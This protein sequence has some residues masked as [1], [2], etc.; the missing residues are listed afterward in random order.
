MNTSICAAVPKGD[1]V[2]LFSCLFVC[3]A[4]GPSSYPKCK[5]PSVY[6]LSSVELFLISCGAGRRR[7]KPRNVNDRSNWKQM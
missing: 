2:G 7:P 6:T 1:V 5:N 3:L 4:S